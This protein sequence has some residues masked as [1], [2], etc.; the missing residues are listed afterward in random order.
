MEIKDVIHLYLGI[1][2]MVQRKDTKEWHRGTI[3]EVTKRSNHGNWAKVKFDEC[4]EVYGHNSMEK[5]F[6]NFHTYFLS[7]DTIKP[8][9]RNLNSMTEEESAEYK[10]IGAATGTLRGDIELEAKR[11]AYLLSKS[12]DLFNLHD[13]N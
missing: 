13:E 7:E 5:S 10:N 4:V 8:I 1:D 9:L 12:F 11:T 3:V 6:S 2:A